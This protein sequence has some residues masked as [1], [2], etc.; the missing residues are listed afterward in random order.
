MPPKIAATVIRLNAT[1]DTEV[2]K[3][4]HE[5]RRHQAEPPSI[6]EAVRELLELGLEAA[7]K[8]TGKHR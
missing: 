4:I 1:V 6:S 7:A 3:K 8:N 2:M 5:W